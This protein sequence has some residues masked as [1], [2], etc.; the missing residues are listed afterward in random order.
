VV[1]PTLRGVTEREGPSR[2]SSDAPPRPDRT[3]HGARHMSDFEALMWNL[4]KDRRLSST[5]ANLTMFDQPI[6]LDR[7]RRRL[8]RAAAIV[9]RLHQRVVPGFGRLAPPSWQVDDQFDIDHHLR[10]ISLGGDATPEQ[11]HETVMQIVNDPF[12]RTRP[13][14]EFTVIE[15]LADGRA[16]MVQKLHHTLMD[17][18][19]G[20]RISEQFVDF[21]RD[22]PE[23]APVEIDEAERAH[24]SPDL[25]SSVTASVGH[26]TR[27]GLGAARRGLGDAAGSITDPLGAARHG[28]EQIHTTASTLSQARLDHRQLST[29]WTTRS[30]RRWLGTL[31]VPLD[32]IRRLAK[33]HGVSVND[34]FVTGAAHG[35]AR[36]HVGSGAPTESLRMAMPISTRRDGSA[37]GNMFGLAQ[38]VVPTG[39]MTATERLLA[40]SEILTLTKTERPAASLDGVAGLVNML[41]TSVVVRAGF[42]LAASVD[43]VTSNLRA[44]PV[45]VF[46]GGALM[47]ANYPMGPLSGTAFNLTTMSYR[48]VLNM[49]LVVDAGAIHEP[50][51]LHADIRWAF[52]ELLADAHER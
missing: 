1:A 17:G 2:V 24:H 13:L 32:E 16:A 42:R 4:D 51:R 10:W 33:A 22:A 8:T 15:G 20:L 48:G 27:R 49:G 45:D 18:E 19:G 14:W 38:A 36:Y 28:R 30:L 39:D 52:D 44:A 3:I 25:W 41:P 23:L 50:D 9:P 12:D 11:L 26:L 43:F 35:A 34:V 29:L 47:E 6:D 40:V 37:G 5:I 7:F 21:E 31:D 46:M